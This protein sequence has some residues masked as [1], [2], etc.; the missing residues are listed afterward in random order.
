MI[1]DTDIGAQ[2]NFTGLK[3]LSANI[4]KGV[5]NLLYECNNVSYVSQRTGI[6]SQ[7]SSILEMVVDRHFV[8]QPDRI[9]DIALKSHSIMQLTC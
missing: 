5:V 3:E 8:S 4:N 7:R 2:P 9:S 1:A 6:R